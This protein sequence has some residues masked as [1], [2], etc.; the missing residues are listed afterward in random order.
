[1]GSPLSP[2]LCHMV[3]L[4][5]HSSSPWTFLPASYATWT[6]ALVDLSWL[7]EPNITNFLRPDFYGKPIIPETEPDQEF[8]GFLL[9][10]EPFALR[11]IHHPEV[12]APFSASPISVQLSGFVSRLFLVAKS[13]FPTSEQFRGFAALHRLCRHAGFQDEDLVAASKRSANTYM[14][15]LSV[16]KSD[17]TSPCFGS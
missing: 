3:V 4:M 8:L 1:M 17:P 16:A 15:A 11:Y 13:G 5:H 10:L 14:F 2:A 7:S 6:I 12:T 9:E